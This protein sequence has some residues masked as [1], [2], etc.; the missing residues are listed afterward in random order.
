MSE[1]QRPTSG[2]GK[3]AFSQSNC[4]PVHAMVTLLYRTL[5]SGYDMVIQRTWVI[6]AGSNFAFKTAAKP[7]QSS[8]RHG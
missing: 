3:K 2:R 5:Q 7:L 1:S 6:A 4:S 8:R